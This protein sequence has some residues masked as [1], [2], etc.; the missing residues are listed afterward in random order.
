M[1]ITHPL[2]I[3]SMQACGAL[4]VKTRTAMEFIIKTLTLS[5]DILIVEFVCPN[6]ISHQM[7]FVTNMFLCSHSHHSPSLPAF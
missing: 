5:R 2:L 4:L 7:D 1:E 6:L 3:L